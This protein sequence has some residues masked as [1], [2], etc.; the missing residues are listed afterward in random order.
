MVIVLMGPAGAG[1]STI[2]RALAAALGW[3]FVDGDDHH[4]RAN[5]E[6]MR[7][8]QPLTDADRESW[9]RALHAAIARAIDRREHTVVACSTLKGSYRRTLAGGLRSIRFAYLKAPEAVLRERL[10]SRAGHFAGPALLASQLATLEEP[11][12]AIDLDATA[13]PSAIITAIRRELGV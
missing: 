1:K 6:K 2:G 5:L 12:E 9:L 11:G 7:H 10:A 3:H 13:S 8:G 4:P